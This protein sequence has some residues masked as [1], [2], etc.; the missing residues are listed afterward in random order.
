MFDKIFD[1]LVLVWDQVKPWFTVEAYNRAV[2]LRNGRFNRVRGA[3]AWWKW[4][5]IEKVWEAIIV[6]TT[7]R[8]RAQSLHTKDDKQLV[9]ESI[10]KYQV[11]DEKVFLLEVYD[12][13]AAL[14]DTTQGIIKRV[15]TE[16]TWQQIVDEDID[17][18]ITAKAKTEAA[19]WG[20]KIFNVTLTTQAQMMSVRLIGESL[21]IG[22][23]Q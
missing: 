18:I 20:I 22:A 9:L 19:K 4:P 15:I 14:E 11:I 12:A 21:P 1:F 10:I 16:R 6:P 3:G 5:V 2:V 13:L 8:L 17:K 23:V 7:L